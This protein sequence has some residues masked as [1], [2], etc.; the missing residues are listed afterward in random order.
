MQLYFASDMM[1]YSVMTEYYPKIMAIVVA[2]DIGVSEE[3]F[4][5]LMGRRIPF[6][7]SS[8]G[9][10]KQLFGDDG[11]SLGAYQNQIHWSLLRHYPLGWTEIDSLVMAMDLVLDPYFSQAEYQ[12][13][14]YE[15]LRYWRNK[16]GKTGRR[17][18]YLALRSTNR[19]L[20]YFKAM[21]SDGTAYVR[22]VAVGY[23]G[24]GVR[25]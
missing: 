20:D 3:E 13:T 16:Y 2:E 4:K 15:H 11:K 5:D 24:Y 9:I 25:K 18:W 22:A 7:E 17:L 23:P 19:G 8:L 6:R 12:E 10:P 1:A 21:D 14:F